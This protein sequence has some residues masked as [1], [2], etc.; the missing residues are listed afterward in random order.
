MATK[1]LKTT[2]D[3]EN[4]LKDV[5]KN[6]IVVRTYQKDTQDDHKTLETT[7]KMLKNNTK[8]LRMTI[9]TF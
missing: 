6:H 7:I 9:R 2:T 1:T 4:N 5:Q 8:R 3:A